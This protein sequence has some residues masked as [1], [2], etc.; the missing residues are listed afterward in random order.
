MLPR[1][2]NFKAGEKHTY[3]RSVQSASLRSMT[4]CGEVT[5]AAAATTITTSLQQNVSN[6]SNNGAAFPSHKHTT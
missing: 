4:F 5:T 3:H 6:I 2:H 1:A